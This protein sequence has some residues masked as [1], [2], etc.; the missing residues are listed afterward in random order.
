MCLVD[1]IMFQRSLLPHPFLY[2]EDAA[3]S[4]ETSAPTYQ[5]IQHHNPEEHNMNVFVAARLYSRV[6]LVAGI[7]TQLLAEFLSL[8]YLK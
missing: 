4:S 1:V 3:C 6:Y 2:V 5:T 8:K 7:L